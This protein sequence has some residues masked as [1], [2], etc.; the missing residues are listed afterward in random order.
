MGYLLR[1]GVKRDFSF[2]TPKNCTWDIWKWS[3]PPTTTRRRRTT[4]SSPWSVGFAADKKG[5]EV[6][7]FVAQKEK[8]LFEM[9]AIAREGKRDVCYYDF[10]RRRRRRPLQTH[11]DN[12]YPFQDHR[13]KNSPI[14]QHFTFPY[15]IR[16][17]KPCWISKG[18][19]VTHCTPAGLSFGGIRQEGEKGKYRMW[20]QSPLDD[21][22]F[23][24]LIVLSSSPV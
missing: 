17:E 1:R 10:W 5:G 8:P 13:N 19:G 2:H 6:L 14:G 11:N 20:S 18:K 21:D 22:K 23:Q 7:N 16:K 24:S 9:D 15:D 3:P 4:L 12:L